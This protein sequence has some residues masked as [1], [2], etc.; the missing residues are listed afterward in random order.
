MA[1]T[2][3][4]LKATQYDNNPLTAGIA[5]F[6]EYKPGEVTM[7]YDEARKDYELTFDDGQRVMLS[8]CDVVCGG[9]PSGGGK[10]RGPKSSKNAAA[11][12]ARTSEDRIA[13]I[14]AQSGFVEPT[15]FYD[16][17][18]EYQVKYGTQLRASYVEAVAG[19]KAMVKLLQVE[20]RKRDLRPP[21]PVAALGEKEGTIRSVFQPYLN[22]KRLFIRREIRGKVMEE[23]RVFPSSRMDLLDALKIA[24]FKTHK[25]ESNDPNDD[26]DDGD[27]DNPHYSEKAL[28]RMRDRARLQ[29]VSNATGY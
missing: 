23:L 28:K 20:A 26:F 24:I 4:W 7:E 12:V 22:R 29:G 6:A 14:E 18:A 10:A 5:D 9:D 13:I 8:Q 19:F 2:D 25:P 11:V 21:L 3:P 17:L 15:R 16:W 1:E 27:D